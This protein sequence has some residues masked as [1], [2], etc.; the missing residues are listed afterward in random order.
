MNEPL[1]KVEMDD[2]LTSLKQLIADKDENDVELIETERN[3]KLLLG[4]ALRAVEG[5]K[6]ERVQQAPVYPN[7]EAK[8]ATA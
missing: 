1:G 6:L 5:R 7:L 3:G 8:I 4:P 2:V